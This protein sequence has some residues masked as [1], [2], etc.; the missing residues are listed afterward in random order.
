MLQN[1]GIHRRIDWIAFSLFLGLIG[2]GWLM[3]YAASYQDYQEVSF[4][5]SLAGKQ[6]IWIF[7]SLLTFLVINQIDWKIWQTFAFPIYGLCIA[8]LVGVLLLGATIKG[9]T[10]WYVV[11]PF[12]LQP[13]EFAKFGTCLAMAAFLSRYK[14]DLQNFRSAAVSIGIFLLPAGLIML[15]PDAGSA[16]VFTSFMLVL[17]REGLSRLL[18]IIGIALIAMLLAGFLFDVTVI[19]L[20]LSIIGLTI[21]AYQY[22]PRTY[23]MS[24]SVAIGIIASY[25]FWKENQDA[26]F[27]LTL[28]A[29]SLLG[30][31]LLQKKKSRLVLVVLSA[32]SISAA[33]SYVSDY[34]FNNILEPHQR[35]RLNV[36]L[37]PSQDPSG[38]NYNLLQSK[39]AI[40]SG[41]LMGKGI[42][43][44]T[45]TKYNYVPEQSTDFI[46]C[47]IGEEHGFIGVM[48]ILAMFFFL[49]WRII[50]IAERQR[51][52]FSRVFAYSFAGILFVHFFINIGMTM[53]VVPIIGIP[54]PFISKGGSSLLGFTI[55]MAV[56]LKLDKSRFRI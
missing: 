37:K 34:A 54:L 48:S 46:F 15:Q 42:F 52:Q 27:I 13:S 44:G 53:G 1:R 56:L 38:A 36:W 39:M 16:L 4:F 31:L 18:Y 6:L 49:T 7:I 47:T 45:M 8:L 41:G 5:S 51:F 3:I 43:N 33:V 12:S 29:L 25:L 21:L 23:T 17:F 28:A 2:L 50:I 55:M 14:T 19:C 10:S 26:A 20:A 32:M 11:G 40:S 35:D 9:A 22:R 30:I 24:S